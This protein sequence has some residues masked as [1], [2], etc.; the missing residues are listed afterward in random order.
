MTILSD[1]VTDRH[2]GFILY[3]M[4]GFVFMSKRIVIVGGVAGGAST[5]ARIRRLDE[6][7]SIVMFEKGDDVSFSNCSLP[8]YI[9]GDV[10]EREKLV[11]MSPEKFKAWH[12]IDVRV[13]T[14]VIKI[15]RDE[16]CVVVRERE[17][18]KEYKEYYDKL[19]LATGARAVR[20]RSIVG[21]DREN[22][23]TVRNVTDVCR[24]KEYVTAS[25]A[26]NI[27]VAG[28]GFVGLEIAENFKKLG[29]NVSVV[30]GAAQVM[31]PFDYD[32]VQLLHKEIIDNGLA[33]HVNSMVKEITDRSVIAERNGK[34]VEIPADAVVL[35][36]GVAQETGLAAE[37]GLEIG[38]YRGIRVNHNYQTSDPDIYAVGDSIE[39]FDRLGRKYGSFAQAGPA[40]REARAAADHICGL[41][42]NNNGYIATSCLRVFRMNA[43]CTGLNERNARAL[44]IPYDVAY[45]LPFDKVKIMPDSHYMAFK[46]IFEVPTGRILGAQAIGE[47]NVTRRIDVI[48]TMITMGGTLENLKELELCYS[49]VYGTAKDVVN[50]AALVGLNLLSGRIRQ[51]RV[52]DVRKLVEDGAYIVDV[53]ESKEFNKGHLKGAVNIPLSELRERR[54]EIPRDRPVYIHCRTAQRSY[55]ALCGLLGDGYDNVVNISGSFLGVCLNEYFNDKF[56]EREPIVTAYNFSVFD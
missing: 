19:V 41:P 20:P 34:T 50:I 48:A 9:S 24:L 10:P 6:H 47:G 16:K 13:K 36:I 42:H 51:V 44:G 22:V 15:C 30:E 32:M 3:I 1:H 52:S 43:A 11:E 39:T 40:Q 53:R 31:M 25:N 56:E 7:A 45:V 23:F 28:G 17:S 29:K 8:Y 35:S 46:L 49:P 18:G 4:K 21:V 55:F 12:N 26:Q 5:A 33:L 38:S 14:E 2:P 27:V 37:A 54:N